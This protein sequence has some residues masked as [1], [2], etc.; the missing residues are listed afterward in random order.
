M[1]FWVKF[2][3]LLLLFVPVPALADTAHAGP[4]LAGAA[5]AEAALL[6]FALQ[7]V[8]KQG[9]LVRAKIEPGAKITIDDRDLLLDKAGNFIFGFDRDYGSKAE[10]NVTFPDGRTWAGSLDI[11]ARDY[12]I[13]YVEGIAKK[14][15]EPP[16]ETLSRIR[17]EA[18][19]KRAARKGM[20]ASSGY[21]ADFA[22]PLTGR[23]SGVYGS[24]RFYN[25]KPGRPH[26]GLDIAAPSGTYFHAP[27]DG[28]VT[29]ADDDM[30]YEG[31]LIFLDHGLGLTSAFL[32][33]SGVDV[34]PGDVVKKGDVLGRVG[35]AG[36][37]NGPHLDWRMY[38]FDQHID[39]AFLV[40]EMSVEK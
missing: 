37:A 38:W 3:A 19:R 6:P 24:Q 16:A 13:Q 28:V 4:A 5:Q 39:P 35:A 30:Y 8:L 2:L 12:D 22:W 18:K 7:G 15:V 25:G 34:K 32:H 33:L 29:L 9:G 17:A 27:A 40:G 11:T 14:Y 21:L 23:I 31:G 26:F 10:V 36:R 1:R 20:N